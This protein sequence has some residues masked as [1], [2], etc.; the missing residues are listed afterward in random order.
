MANFT[1]KNICSTFNSILNIG[2]SDQDQCCLPL[3]DQIIVTDGIGTDSAL[4]LG[5]AA[6]GITV[7]GSI[8]GNNIVKGQDLCSTN[9]ICGNTVNTTCGIVAGDFIQAK[10]DLFAGATGNACFSVCGSTGLTFAKG[11]VNIASNES[12][13]TVNLTVCGIS[14]F[15]KEIRSCGDV[16]AFYYS[17]FSL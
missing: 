10:G 13:S 5:R 8:C 14:T 17:D 12:N 3:N 16:V 11:K 7:N 1:G 15:S 9:S 6:N 2:S 4:C